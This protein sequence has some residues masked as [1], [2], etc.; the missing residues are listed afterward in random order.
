MNKNY[1][2]NIYFSI[3]LVYKDDNLIVVLNIIIIYDV[4]YGFWLNVEDM[5]FVVLKV[6]I[7]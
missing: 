7:F 1:F 4:F 6:Y 3:I 5:L 2:K